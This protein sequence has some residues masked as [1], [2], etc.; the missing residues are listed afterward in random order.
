MPQLLKRFGGNLAVTDTHACTSSDCINILF[1][2]IRV[3]TKYIVLNLL[4]TLHILPHSG[5]LFEKVP[6]SQIT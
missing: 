3:G 4:L 6:K 5:V 2:R 1:A